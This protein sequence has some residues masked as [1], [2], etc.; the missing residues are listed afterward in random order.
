MGLPDNILP[1]AKILVDPYEF[2]TVFR[3]LFDFT[4]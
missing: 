4:P 3:Q 1:S 2:P